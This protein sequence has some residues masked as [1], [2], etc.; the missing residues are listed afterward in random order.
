MQENGSLAS[1]GHCLASGPATVAG[2]G[3]VS[4]AGRLAARVAGAGPA[5]AL[6]VVGGGFARRPWRSR[7]LEGL[8][9]TSL[10]V[11][12]HDGAPTP[13]SVVALAAHARRY[14]PGVIIGV[15]GG[16]VID[17]AK[18]A[19]ILAQTPALDTGAV[20]RLCA[21]GA[22]GQGLP[23]IAI[24]TTPG[25]GAEATPFA[26]IWDTGRGRKLSLRGAALLPAAAILDPDLLAG[27]PGAQL[28]SCM[29]DTLAQGMEA[30]WS[31]AGDD[32]ASA[33]GQA[34]LAEL[35]GPLG[36]GPRPP[37]AAER[38]ALILAGHYSGRAIAIAGTTLCHALSY[39]LTLRY[40]L[41]HGHACGLTLGRVLAYNR[42]VSG[43]DCADP[44]GPARV[45][46]VTDACLAA[47]GAAGPAELSRR[48]AGFLAAAGLPASTDFGAATGSI[49]ADALSYDRAGNNPRRPD[50]GVLV[51]LL[52]AAHEPHQ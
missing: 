14:R 35:R 48:V 19:A 4:G 3:E 18:C 5:R 25:T 31:A 40:G 17:A 9:G 6:L 24:P 11:A 37:G 50:P 16:S 30:A 51:R 32:T 28:A 38:R 7:V 10:E 21:D 44:R 12:V 41:A 8:A 26:T 45:R 42:A 34:A 22:G 36:A 20:R 47:V 46:Q 15:G 13:G 39:P 2:A 23:V 27:L 52:T 33:F 43:G 1:T 49:V 29:L